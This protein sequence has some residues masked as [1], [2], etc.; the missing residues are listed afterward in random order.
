M[1]KAATP[2]VTLAVGLAVRL[3]AMSKLT[4]LSTALIAFGTA[5]ATASEAGTGEQGWG[6]SQTARGFCNLF[7]RGC[8]A[9][10]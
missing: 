10:V 1:L 3:E 8:R 2:L 5:V 7:S 4:L 6:R 9:V